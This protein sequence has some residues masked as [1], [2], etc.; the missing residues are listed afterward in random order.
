FIRSPVERPKDLLPAIAEGQNRIENKIDEL[1]GDIAERVV[2]LLD[3]S[4]IAKAADAGLERTTI[5]ELARPL[6]SGEVID[7]DQA[8]VE[9]RHAVSIALDVIAKGERGS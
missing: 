6:R 1:P 8:I 9:L 5:L 4:E 3:K 7:L 2:A